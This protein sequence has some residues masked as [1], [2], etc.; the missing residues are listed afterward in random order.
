MSPS[1]ESDSLQR[2]VD[3][4]NRRYAS[5]SENRAGAEKY[6]ALKKEFDRRFLK[7]ISFAL[8][9]SADKLLMRVMPFTRKYS[10][11]VLMQLQQPR[12]QKLQQPRKAR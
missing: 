6:Y 3:F 8:L 9:D 12:K 11:M 4:H 10:W 7:N 2:E 5:E 1:A